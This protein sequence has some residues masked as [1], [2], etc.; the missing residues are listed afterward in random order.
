[1]PYARRSYRRRS[2]RRRRTPWYNKKYSTAQIARAA[3]RSAK[4]IRGLVNSE[5]FH[6]DQT[7]TLGS[8]QNA[9][10]NIT[11][12][13]IG[14]G[15]NARTANSILAKSIHM[16]GYMYINPTVTSNTRVM[17][18]LVRDT[19]Q[20]SDTVPSI[21]NIFDSAISPHTLLN[22]SNA[23]RFKI[24]WRK[25][26][27]MTPNTGGR[28]AIQLKFFTRLNHHVRYNGSAD[29][30]IQKNGIYLVMITS[31][32]TNYPTIELLSRFNYHDN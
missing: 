26:Y 15:M 25:Q 9:I 8:N 1:M 32:P 28:D 11:S 2:S 13:A 4:Y 21:P 14:D 30:D 7:L 24:L 12:L 3:W 18:A 20:V 16:R 31:E 19:Q 17:L 5:M 23:G 27:V 29:T 6:K 10:F 22:L